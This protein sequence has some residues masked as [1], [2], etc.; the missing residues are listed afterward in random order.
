MHTTTGRRPHSSRFL[1]LAAAGGLPE[2]SGRCW[3]TSG[4]IAAPMHL[5]CVRKSGRSQRRNDRYVSAAVPPLRATHARSAA[6]PCCIRLHAHAGDRAAAA[7]AAGADA[8]RLGQRRCVLRYALVALAR[9]DD[10]RHASA[11]RTRRGA[12]VLSGERYEAF[13]QALRA[14]W[15][16]VAATAQNAASAQSPLSI[17]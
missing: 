9:R 14:H 2:R 1:A 17:E 10:S 3:M 13:N 7:D 8:D 11:H 15:T 16:T 4:F 6:L 5:P 12:L